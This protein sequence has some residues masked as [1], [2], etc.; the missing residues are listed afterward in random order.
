MRRIL[1]TAACSVALVAAAGV[2]VGPAS[3]SVPAGTSN[4]IAISFPNGTKQ[5]AVLKE[6]E[7]AEETAAE[8]GY[9]LIIDDPGNDQQRQINTI[10]TWIEQGVLAI[11]AQPIA[12]ETI[13]ATAEKARD[14]G[15]FWITYANA[16]ENQDATLGFDHIAGGNAIGAAACEFAAAELGGEAT[17]A[18]LTFE[19]G[20]WA[21]FRREGIEQGLASC[22]AEIE[23][24]ARQDALS[25][26]EGLNAMSTILQANPDV[27]IVLAVAET[28][29]EGAYQAFVDAGHAPD[30]GTL[31]LAGIDG[32][33]RALE[34]IQQ[35][36]F[37]RASAALSL[38]EVGRGMV[39][40][41]EALAAGE[42]GDYLVPLE[43]VT[44]DTPELLEK[45]IEELS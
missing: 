3:A 30:D 32:T 25:Q 34:L 4:V 19:P 22:D 40:L 10:D 35:G 28:A 27:N 37:Y 41:P 44:V 42:T 24:V 6:F 13:E 33:A 21:Q 36:T 5:D 12:A 18:L 23:I 15:I 1:S 38:T 39:L 26:T 8:L 45:Y 20:P 2:A 31:F 7:V 43:L 14:A 9:E 17:A 16:I 11:I 29:T